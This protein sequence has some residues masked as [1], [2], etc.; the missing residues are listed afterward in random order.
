MRKIF[1]FGLVFALIASMAWSQVGGGGSGS[2]SIIGPLGSSTAPSA[3]VATTDTGTPITGQTMP[4][5]GQGLSGWLSAIYNSSLAPT[6]PTGAATA[7]KQATLNGDGGSAVHINGPLGNATGV[8]G[9]PSVVLPDELAVS[10]SVTS[11]AVLFTQDMSGYNSVSLTTTANASGNTV[12]YEFSDDNS[13]WVAGAG[14][15]IGNTGTAGSSTSNNSTSAATLI[16][17]KLGRYFRARV[18]TYISG[19]T[20]VAGNL[21]SAGIVTTVSAATIGLA[22]TAAIGKSGP[23]YTSA[24]TPI[25]GVGTGTTAAVTATLAAA[26]SKLTYICGFDITADATA[27]ATGTATLV[28]LGTTLTYVQTIT[29]VTSGSATLTRTFSP[30]LPSSAVNTAVVVTSAAAGTGGVTN[31]NAW[32]YQ[33]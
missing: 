3:A 18:S 27:L 14:R 25:V 6:L 28:G 5:G 13:T 22:G 26:S 4:A 2:S 7:A 31:A 17:P 30:C 16:F 15:A 29:A 1:A 21:H 33:E 12:T 20:T 19:T 32:G 23:G 10:G 24:Q 9:T 11:A 8:S